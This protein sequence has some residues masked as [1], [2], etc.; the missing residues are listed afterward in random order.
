M[1][2]SKSFTENNPGRSPF[3]PLSSLPTWAQ[4]QKAPNLSTFQLEL[5][6]FV[7]Q[8]WG[9]E[10]VFTYVC[11]TSWMRPFLAASLSSRL[12]VITVKPIIAQWRWSLKTSGKGVSVGIATQSDLVSSSSL[13]LITRILPD[14]H[15]LRPKQAPAALTE[16]K[17]CPLSTTVS[18]G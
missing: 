14:G 3:Q 12:L 8:G 7:E 18:V 2:I 11:I 5:Y 9:K 1:S 10:F 17:L 15:K 16:A 4:R 6:R 13:S